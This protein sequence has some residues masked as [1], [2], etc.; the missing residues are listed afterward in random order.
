MPQLDTSTW[1]TVISSMI[2]TLFIIFQLKVSKLNYPLNLTLKSLSNH[3]RTNP[4]ESKWTKIYSPLSL[5][6]QS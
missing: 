6:Q 2:L 5:P 3:N 4:W 1:F